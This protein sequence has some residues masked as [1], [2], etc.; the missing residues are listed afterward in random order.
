MKQ[1]VEF[2]KLLVVLQKKSTIPGF[3]IG[4]MPAIITSLSIEFF[5]GRI[6]GG[7]SEASITGFKAINVI[8]Y[9]LISQS[10][11][12]S[13]T[14]LNKYKKIIKDSYLKTETVILSEIILQFINFIFLFLLFAIFFSFPIYII[15]LISILAIF[16]ILYII[17]LS[18]LISILAV[19]LDDFNRVLGIILQV[20]F[21]LSPIIYILR[22]INSPIK[23]LIMIN[24]FHI[25]Y[26]CIYLIFHGFE[27]FDNEIMIISTISFVIF[28]L[29]IFML[30]KNLRKKIS[31]F[32]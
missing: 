13:L 32:L 24:P 1:I 14:S 16:T 2:T 29:F 19:V 11:S 15:L 23:Y 10:L 7:N 27:K 31:L 9:F 8:F 21:W 30:L 22:D 28:S 6:I 20:S 12:L 25:F 4:L 17:G 3:L 26:E 5:I 18:I